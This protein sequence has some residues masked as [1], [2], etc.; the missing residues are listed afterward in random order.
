MHREF[1]DAA[2]QNDYC[3]IGTKQIA[4]LQHRCRFHRASCA[5][6]KVVASQFL[7]ICLRKSFIWVY[8]NIGR[9]EF[10]AKIYKFFSRI[11]KWFGMHC[12]MT[13][14]WGLPN[15][16]VCV[17]RQCI[18]SCCCYFACVCWPEMF[19]NLKAINV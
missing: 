16:Y 17:C 18:C 10:W 3:E 6:R 15:V 7:S 9:Y 8:I 14:F 2:R 19:V 13:Q 11:F 12:A 5:Y 1:S 4:L